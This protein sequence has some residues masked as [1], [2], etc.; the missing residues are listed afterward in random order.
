MFKSLLLI[1]L[2]LFTV[3][4]IADSSKVCV[5]NQAGGLIVLTQ[6]A[7]QIPI[8]SNSF[9]FYGYATEANGTF[10][11]GCFNIPKIDDA[12]Q[13]PGV[14]IVPV[15]NFID[16]NDGEIITFEAEVF[17]AESCPVSSI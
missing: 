11:E 2:L 10:H 14:R 12:Q 1:I 3:S 8:V 6:E 9:P 7:C 17:R 13:S 15:V 16:G 5:R 4:A